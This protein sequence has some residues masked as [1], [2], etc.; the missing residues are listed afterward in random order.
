[1]HPA[2]TPYEDQTAPPAMGKSSK[3]QP[4]RSNEN[5]EIKEI[6]RETGRGDALQMKAG[7][8]GVQGYPNSKFKAS[9]GYVN[10]TGPE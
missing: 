3:K 4:K 6:K 7:K 10:E 2:L 8:L 1:M 5:L 9:L